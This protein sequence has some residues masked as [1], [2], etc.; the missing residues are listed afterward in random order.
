MLILSS[1][2]TQAMLNNEIYVSKTSNIQE[3]KE[4]IFKKIENIYVNP[5]KNSNN[6]SQA[7]QDLLKQKCSVL[8][9]NAY[10]ACLTLT[11]K[12]ISKTSQENAFK[13]IWVCS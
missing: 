12:T 11:Q 4:D 1:I 6:I 9:R 2:E 10:S 5:N 3:K 8:K 13:D 7:K